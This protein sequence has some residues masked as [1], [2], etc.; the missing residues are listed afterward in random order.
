MKRLIPLL[1]AACMITILSITSLGQEEPVRRKYTLT[2]HM[3]AEEK[4]LFHTV[5]EDFE[6]TD[7]PPGEIHNIAEYEKMEGVLIGYPGTFG[8]PYTLIAALSE[9]VPVTTIVEN[10]SQ[11]NYVT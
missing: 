11:L 4:A 7:P 3:S 6:P 10:N 5:G 2:H 8:I 9:E 1:L